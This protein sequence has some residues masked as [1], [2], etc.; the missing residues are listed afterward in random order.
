MSGYR[1]QEVSQ[2]EEALDQ[3]RMPG[4]GQCYQRGLGLSPDRL[5]QA[6][7]CLSDFHSFGENFAELEIIQIFQSRLFGRVH[8][9]RFHGEKLS[10]ETLKELFSDSRNLLLK[11]NIS[12]NP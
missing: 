7:T 10:T 5:L 6:E 3:F 11:I 9:F 8:A 2:P 4:E 12:K 1:G